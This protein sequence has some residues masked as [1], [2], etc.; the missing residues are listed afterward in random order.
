MMMKA[1]LSRM[2]TLRRWLVLGLAAFALSLAAYG[3]YALHALRTAFDDIAPTIGKIQPVLR[4]AAPGSVVLSGL[5]TLATLERIGGLKLPSEL[6]AD[7]M[8]VFEAEAI[9]PNRGKWP[10]PSASFGRIGAFGG[11]TRPTIIRLVRRTIP[12]SQRALGRLV[13]KG[14]G[15]RYDVITDSI[16][17]SV[18]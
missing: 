17:D 16:A 13:I 6:G 11:Y 1:R 2:S 18:S 15:L 9:Q 5:D 12:D 3:W 7:S 8:L 14:T 10:P 4:D